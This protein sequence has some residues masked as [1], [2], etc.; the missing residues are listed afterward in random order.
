MREAKAVQLVRGGLAKRRQPLTTNSP[1]T[2][3]VRDTGANDGE[4]RVATEKRCALRQW[5]GLLE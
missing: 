5:R 4:G 2:V 3:C 1:T